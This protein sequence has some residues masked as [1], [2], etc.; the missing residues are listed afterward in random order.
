MNKDGGA[1]ME[2][3]KSGQTQYEEYETLLLERDQ[4]QKEAGQ[5]W[6]V[7]IQ[8]F[9]KLIADVYEEKIECIKCRK[10]IAY[11]Q[12]ALNR[13]GIIDQEAMQQYLEQEMASYYR[14]L[15]HMQ[16]DYRKC[17]NAGT[18][19]PYEVQRSRTLYR[20]LAKLIHPDIFPETDRNETLRELWQRILTAYSHND[21]KALSEL[22]VLA[23]KA[24]K[25]AGSKEIKIDIPEIGEKIDALKEEIHSI[26]HTD[27]YT[28]KVLLEDDEAIRKKQKELQ[29][30]LD[31][32][33][34]YRK[35]LEEAIHQI[36]TNGGITI[37]WRMN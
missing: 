23:R 24:L 2:L 19:T 8:T 20:R 30:E 6:T 4:L 21:I 11:Y 15:A 33:Q 16:D 17:K 22:E 18:S 32:Y 7:Y 36:I 29:D 25:E 37:Q 1:A 10:T 14:N 31:T 28:Y 5:I 35:E 27:P 34:K 12:R 13:G 26:L 9:G 3:L